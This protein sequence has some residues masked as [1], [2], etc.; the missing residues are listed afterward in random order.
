LKLHKTMHTKAAKK[1]AKKRVIFMKEF[2]R[3][4]AKEV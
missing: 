1:A 2:L 3:Q 4:M